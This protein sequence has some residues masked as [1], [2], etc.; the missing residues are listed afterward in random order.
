MTRDP[1]TCGQFVG[2]DREAE[3]RDHAI[4]AIGE[5]ITWFKANLDG[6]TNELIDGAWV[7]VP[8]IAITPRDLAMLVDRLQL[9]CGR[10]AQIS[11]GRTFAASATSEAIPVDALA[12][13]VELTRRPA[14]SPA[15]TSALPYIS[16]DRID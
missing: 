3:V 11:E 1:T 13:I 16:D 10:Q 9:L 5:A 12:K 2:A 8:A 14:T 15:S 4:D 7:E 6:T